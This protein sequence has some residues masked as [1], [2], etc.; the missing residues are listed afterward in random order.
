[1]YSIEAIRALQ[2]KAERESRERGEE[3]QRFFSRDADVAGIPFLGERCP[4]GWKR[5]DPRKAG[6]PVSF[7]HDDVVRGY[8]A[9][10][11]D[12]SGFGTPDEPAM[13]FDRFE[14]MVD[15][16]GRYG[17]AVVQAG[18]F[19]VYVGVFERREGREE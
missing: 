11:V 8:P 15:R 6:L 1:M 5:V 14:K 17:Y 18:Q 2:R 13:T 19:Q 9:Y 7:L 4:R 12:S 10:F 16:T 3:P